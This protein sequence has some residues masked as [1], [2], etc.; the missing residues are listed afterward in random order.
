VAPFASIGGRLGPDEPMSF[1]SAGQ[2]LLSVNAPDTTRGP[3]DPRTTP[4]PDSVPQAT[5]IRNQPQSMCSD[6]ELPVSNPEP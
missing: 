4:S 2:R 5:G 1:D 3:H 6:P